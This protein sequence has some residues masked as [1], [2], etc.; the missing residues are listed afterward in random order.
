[1]HMDTEIKTA[2]LETL[3]VVRANF[4]SP[5][6]GSYPLEKITRAAVGTLNA[7]RDAGAAAERH[8]QALAR[9]S[10][11]EAAAEGLDTNSQSE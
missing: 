7:W 4:S 5:V 2:I 9:R 11:R 3:R 6:E 1:M 8:Y 10:E